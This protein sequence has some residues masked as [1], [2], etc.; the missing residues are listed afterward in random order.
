MSVLNIKF[1]NFARTVLTAQATSVD[2]TITV[3]SSGAFPSLSAG[4]WFYVVLTNSLTNPT[5]R[6][7]L[8]V[9][10]MAGNV[11]TVSRSQEG[12]SATLWPSG[13]YV[14]LRLTAASIT[15]L[16]S[17]I[18]YNNG[19][20]GATNRTITSRLQDRVS[21]TDFGAVKT[22]DPLSYSAAEGIVNYHAFISAL[23][24]VEEGAT[25]F[26]PD[27]TFWLSAP[28]VITKAQIQIEGAGKEITRLGTSGT[29]AIT[30][31]ATGAGAGLARVHIRN[32]ELQNV[33]TKTVGEYGI[34]AHSTSLADAHYNHIYDN[35][36]V[37]GFD[38]GISTTYHNASFIQNIWVENCNIG[39]YNKRS[40]GPIYTNVYVNGCDDVGIY[41]DGDAGFVTQSAGTIY[42]SCSAYNCGSNGNGANVY[43]KYH[44]NF[45]ISNCSFGVP[46]AAA[47]TY[48]VVLESSARCSVTNSWLV[49]DSVGLNMKLYELDECIFSNNNFATS[50]GVGVIVEGSQR[51]IFSGNTFTSNASYDLEVKDSSPGAR[52]SYAN[53]IFGNSFNS[54]VDPVSVSETSVSLTGHNSNYFGN[55]HIG[56]L[57]IDTTS[58]NLA[59]RLLV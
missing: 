23:A 30:I 38:I 11:W 29:G 54:S 6:E 4:E 20:G 25:I 19:L 15:D 49:G 36:R 33:G 5:V 31:D 21:I 9:T 47:G 24:N 44:E 12:T 53:I 39:I 3:E 45:Q 46:S 59:N 8:K 58:Q 7:I 37:T 35:I 42:Q 52:A 48:N 40:L 13:T 27:G 56:T 22:S 14:E 18:S 55:V 2:N 43:I 10:S 50:T 1:K 28:I 26:V 51:C 16:T 17:N 32:I 41:S 57:S 34:K